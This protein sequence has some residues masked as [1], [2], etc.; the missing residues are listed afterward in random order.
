MKDS[1]FIELLNLYVDHQI[2]A[3]DAA[4]LEAEIQRSPERRRVYRQYCQ[5]Q[6]ACATLAETFRTQAPASGNLIEMP[7][8]AR[9]P[10]RIATYAMGAL[11]AAACVALVIVQRDRSVE[12]GALSSQSVTPQVAV[13][14]PVAP[15]QEVVTSV[16]VA[17]RPALQP[18]FAGL[19]HEQKPVDVSFAAT[20]P[21]DWMNRIQIERM[22]AQ[23]IWFE[24]QSP[25]QP[26]DYIFRDRRPADPQTTMAAFR[27]QR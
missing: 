6:K 13:A 10:L 14:A 26:S 4:Q 7:R 2:S 16:P 9:S 19:V 25:A 3:E 20:G 21:L 8:S 12:P 18:A 11:A 15:T 5:M 1:K 24:S 27:F 22:P 17:D 23:E